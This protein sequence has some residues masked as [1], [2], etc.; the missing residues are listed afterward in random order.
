MN[1]V[2]NPVKLCLANLDRLPD[3]VADPGYAR[4][5]L[6]PGILHIGVGNFHR[7]HQ[8][9]YLDRLFEQGR[10]LDW[11]VVGAGIKP[12]DAEQRRR[13]AAQDWLTTVVD[14]SADGSSARVVG[15]M[16]DFCEVRA[17]AII[18][19]LADPAIRIVSLTITEGGYYIDATTGGFDA[20]HPEIRHDAEHPGDPQTVFGVLL[21]ALGQRRARGLAP[22]TVLSCDNV[23]QNGD[24]TRRTVLGLAGLVSQDQHDWI[25]ATVAFPNAMVDC[26]TPATSERERELLAD[27]FGLDDAAPVVCEPFRQWVIEDNFPQ[28]RPALE[29][30]G[31]QF[32]D[33][34]TPYETMK[35]RILNASHMAIAYPSA[36]LGYETVHD[37]MD[38]EDIARWMMQLMR[39]EVIPVLTPIPGLDFDDYLTTCARRFANPALGDTIARLCQDASNRLPKFVLPT[40]SDALAHGA[41]VDGLALEIA[42][43]SRMCAAAADSGIDLHDPRSDQLTSAARAARSDPAAFLGLSEVFGDLGRNEPFTKAFA[44]HLDEVSTRGPRE[45]L[46]RFMD[47]VEA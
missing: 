30:V 26:I 29:H 36:L 34:V 27:R 42:F 38:D 44:W 7:S 40:V 17:E 31:V 23:P 9:V 14:L 25:A 4:S 1:R 19:R 2:V 46:R 43:W 37:A 12:Y 35:L 21:A 22:F 5:S 18:A 28:G 32:V 20:A 6:S 10:D 3:G 15:S 8:M 16:V 45:A 11:A 24:V 39:R 33:D 47:G 41:P 13:L